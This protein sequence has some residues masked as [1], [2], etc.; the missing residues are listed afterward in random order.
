MKI[1]DWYSRFP[2]L[3]NFCGFGLYLTCKITP[4]ILWNSVVAPILRLIPIG[5]V[6]EMG[7]MEDE[8]RA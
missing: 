8:K 4:G 3:A 6:T 1:E 5:Q 2:R 7:V